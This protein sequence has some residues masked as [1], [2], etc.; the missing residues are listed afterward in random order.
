MV[1]D[2]SYH[3]RIRITNPSINSCA[4]SKNRFGKDVY[5]LCWW[6]ENTLGKQESDQGIGYSQSVNM[7]ESPKTDFQ[8]KG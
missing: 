6:S 4:Q 5:L 8:M 2:I 1:S 7:R 3:R